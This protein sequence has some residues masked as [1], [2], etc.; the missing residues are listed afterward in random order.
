MPDYKQG[1]IYAIRSHQTEQI[2][3]GSTTQTLP[4]RFGEHKKKTNACNSKLI[5]QY[6]DAYIELIE[7]FPCNSKEELNKKEGEHIRLNNCVNKLIAGRTQNERRKE[8]PEKY[9]KECQKYRETHKEHLKQYLKDYQETNKDKIKEQ[10]KQFYEENKERIIQE[11]ISYSQRPE[12]REKR[13][14]YQKEYMR[15]RRNKQKI[16]SQ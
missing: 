14:E 5:L 12:V 1:K 11:Q 6:E 15:Q 3:I 16:I 4:V 8:C 13:R 7:L 2:Y 9:L 10:R